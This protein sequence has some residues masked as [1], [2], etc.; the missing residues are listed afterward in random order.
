MFENI[1]T[2][3]KNTIIV[4]AGTFLANFFNLLYQLL[5]AHKLAPADFAAFN[6]LLALFMV[7]SSPLSTLQMVVTKYCAE[8]NAGSQINKVKSLLSGFFKKAM[9]LGLV[10]LL[11]FLITSGYLMNTL[12]IPQAACGYILAVLLG[13]SCLNP[14]FLGAL[15]GLELFGWFAVLSVLISV[16]KLILAFIFILLGYN[17]AGALGA[18]LCATLIGLIISY[19][20]LRRFISMRPKEEDI[21]Y[22]QIL[23]YSFPVAISY[24]CFMG[25]VS[26]DMVLVKYYFSFQEAG[27][28]SLAQMV[29][30]V[31]LFLP[32]AISIVMFARTSGLEAKN[33]NTTPTL[34]KSLIYTG[35]L[36]AVAA[37][38]YNLY[39]S[40]VFK[41]LTG[42]I[43]AESIM[44][45]RL[46][47]ISMSFFALLFVL[48]SYFLSKK[49]L[50][51]IKYL[52]ASCLLQLCAIALF[53]KSFIQ[54]QLILCV[55]AT[56]IFCIHLSL[57]Y[58]TKDNFK[59]SFAV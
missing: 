8:F 37:I 57:A 56:L 1:D 20:P 33:M 41:V 27:L 34:E 14:I 3:T 54:V 9:G 38:V 49:D 51:F 58:K 30:K 26:L 59:G 44:L 22:R 17:I 5:I 6:A 53:H 24:F 46:F 21:H 23:V 52:A 47:S 45:G 18:L 39:P 43:F 50:R 29:G 32:G 16:L 12:K 11:V 36:C 13:L 28:Y 48:I 4:F 55:N 2:F 35:V 25:L 40:F 42:K 19:F 7:V 10:T 15:Q 31:F